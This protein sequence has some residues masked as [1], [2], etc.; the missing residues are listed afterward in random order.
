MTSITPEQPTDQTVRFNDHPTRSTQQVDERPS[1]A[2]PHL[3]VAEGSGERPPLAD[4]VPD[5]IPLRQQFGLK[6]E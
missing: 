1:V 6:E 4:S 2:A 3:A 5:V